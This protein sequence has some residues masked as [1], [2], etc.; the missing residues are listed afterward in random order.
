L[1][2]SSSDF[3][4]FAAGLG[5]FC[6]LTLDFLS[7]TVVCLNSFS[8]SVI[9]DFVLSA[10]RFLYFTMK[11]SSTAL[12]VALG[13]ADLS[14]AFTNGTLIPSYMCGQNDGYPH[15]LGQLLPFLQKDQGHTL[16][17]SANS[18]SMF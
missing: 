8:T 15:A 18:K 9:L 12:L 13:L 4:H 14:L 3:V 2:L 5:G 11:V 17:F 6:F 7:L 1:Q 16:A 10:T